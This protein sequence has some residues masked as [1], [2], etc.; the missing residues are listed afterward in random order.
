[1]IFVVKSSDGQKQNILERGTFTSLKSVGFELWKH[2]SGRKLSPSG[3]DDWLK[4]PKECNELI[5]YRIGGSNILK[6]QDK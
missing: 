5:K 6:I 4:W 1:M 3:K 2:T